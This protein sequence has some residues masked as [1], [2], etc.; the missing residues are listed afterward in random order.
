MEVTE[1]QGR[2]GAQP[3]GKDVCFVIDQPW[4]SRF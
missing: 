3:L 2:P 4:T 1:S